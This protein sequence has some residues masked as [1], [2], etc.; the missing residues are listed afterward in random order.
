MTRMLKIHNYRRATFE[1]VYISIIDFRYVELVLENFKLERLLE[2][3]NFDNTQNTI[4][5]CSLV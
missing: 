2:E 4:F 3:R 1:D 5:T